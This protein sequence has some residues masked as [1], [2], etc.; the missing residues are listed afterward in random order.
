M[1]NY[2][3]IRFAKYFQS[4]FAKS[5]AVAKRNGELKMMTYVYK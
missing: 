2:L 5:M 1:F 3:Y 4:L